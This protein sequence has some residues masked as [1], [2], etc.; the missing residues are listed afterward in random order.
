MNYW[1][2]LLMGLGLVAPPVSLYF[3]LRAKSLAA[4]PK[5]LVAALILLLTSNF[6]LWPYL[7]LKDP[8][9]SFYYE[10]NDHG[11]RGR[12]TT[13]VPGSYHRLRRSFVEYKASKGNTSLQFCRT[14]HRK[15]Y[16]FWRWA[17]YLTEPRYD[18]P[19]IEPKY[20]PFPDGGDERCSSYASDAPPLY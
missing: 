17:E 6:T 20:C 5:A 8:F 1:N 18:L 10:S 9:P 11:F 4:Q 14:F 16:V 2:L 12:E 7:L 3:L 15:P 19:F 13:K